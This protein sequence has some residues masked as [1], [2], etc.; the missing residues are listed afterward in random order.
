ME[1]CCQVFCKPKCFDHDYQTDQYN[2]NIP[3]VYQLDYLVFSVVFT[4]QLS[5][6]PGHRTN[7]PPGLID[8]L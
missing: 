1:T 4:G 7:K 6:S 8:T 5:R 3:I 2:A